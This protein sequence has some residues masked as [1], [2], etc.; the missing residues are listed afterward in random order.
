DGDGFPDLVEVMRG[1]VDT[2]RAG[3]VWISRGHGVPGFPPLPPPPEPKDTDGDGILDR[4]DNC[5]NVA[6]PNQADQDGDGFG[7]ACDPDLNNDGRI[8]QS[9]MN[10]LVQCFLADV[11]TRLACAT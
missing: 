8:D 6:N 7:T 1:A 11:S 9:D 3:D 5:T 10:L 4:V 2:H